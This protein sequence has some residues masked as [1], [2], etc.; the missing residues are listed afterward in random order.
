MICWVS[1]VCPI[2]SRDIFT[3]ILLCTIIS[4]LAYLAICIYYKTFQP[5]YC[6]ALAIIDYYLLLFSNTAQHWKLRVIKKKK[7]GKNSIRIT[8][9]YTGCEPYQGGLVKLNEF[10]FLRAVLLPFFLREYSVAWTAQ[11]INGFWMNVS[12]DQTPGWSDE[13]DLLEIIQFTAGLVKD[14]SPRSL[15]SSVLKVPANEVPTATVI[16]LLKIINMW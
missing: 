3:S 13:K 11:L 10:C 12:W 9:N 2:A 1:A 14:Y 16:L 4:C 8:V 15:F 6:Q 5:R 7:S